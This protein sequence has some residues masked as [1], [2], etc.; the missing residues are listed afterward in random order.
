M[1]QI[2]IVEPYEIMRKGLGSLITEQG[3][4]RIVAEAS[5]VASLMAQL[6]HVSIDIL[7]IEPLIAWGLN[8]ASL[9]SNKDKVQS[10]RILVFSESTSEEHVQ[11]A[12]R[13]GVTG[14]VSKRAKLSELI[15]GIQTLARGE[16]FLCGEVTAKLT[17]CIINTFS[18][19]PHELLSSRELQILLL[20]VNGKSMAEVA[21]ELNLSAKTVS[22][23]KMRLMQ[24]MGFDS[25]SRLVQYAAAHGLIRDDGR[26]PA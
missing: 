7:V 20:L 3:G 17:Q 1:I 10:F 18:K 15:Q 24:K 16:P 19:H 8:L 11:S 6:E 23:H 5:S 25:F 2:G 22:T 9:R 21:H 12:L 14:F 13:A 4:M 26:A